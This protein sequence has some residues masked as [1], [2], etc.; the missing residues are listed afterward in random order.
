MAT[1]I[2]F[3]VYI[4]VGRLSFTL[5]CLFCDPGKTRDFFLEIQQIDILVFHFN[6]LSKR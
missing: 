1:L 3:L 6:A 2:T 5:P 4:M